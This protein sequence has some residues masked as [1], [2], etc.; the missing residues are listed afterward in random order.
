[1]AA[2]FNTQ[3]SDVMY[4][5]LRHVYSRALYKR[6]RKLLRT[7]YAVYEKLQ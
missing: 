4:L 1:M 7:T 2:W 6:T 5:M 3:F